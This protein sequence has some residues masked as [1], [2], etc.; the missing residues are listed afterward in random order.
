MAADTREREIGGVRVPLSLSTSCP[1]Y[2][3]TRPIPDF[4][5]LQALDSAPSA[6]AAG[7]AGRRYPLSAVIG[8]LGALW[9]L[10]FVA[11]ADETND[12]NVMCLLAQMHLRSPN[13][14]GL[15][16]ASREAAWRWIERA[17]PLPPDAED[18]VDAHS[19]AKALFPDRYKQWQEQQASGTIAAAPKTE[20]KRKGS[21][22]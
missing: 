12:P 4:S 20:R 14:W 1:S 22:E 6:A 9:S 5:V 21:E 7:S 19:V 3:A 15:M 11:E 18:E 16:S 17:L 10:E 13:G 2:G 8:E